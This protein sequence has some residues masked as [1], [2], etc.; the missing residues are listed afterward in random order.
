[1]PLIVEYQALLDQLAEA[2]APALTQMP[3]E[4]G[5]EMFRVAQP[6]RPD[7]EVK[8]VENRTIE[9]RNGSIPIRIYSPTGSGPFPVTMMFHGGGWVIGDLMTVDAQSR[10]VCNQVG[11]VVVAVDYRL[12]PE[13]RF[14]A[15]TEDCFDATAWVHANSSAINADPNRLAV[16]GDSAGGNLAAV[17]AQMARDEAG[18]PLVFQLLVY[19]VTNGHVFETASYREN[20]EGYML[21]AEAMHWFWDHYAD[22]NDRTHPYASPLLS[23]ELS[24]LPAAYVQVAEFDPLR[25]EGL[26]Y[27]EA[28]ANAGVSVRSTCYD[29]FIHGFFSHFDTIPPTRVAMDDACSALRE[30]F[31]S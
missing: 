16:S 20:A 10:Q 29:G 12:A 31:N 28:L 1:M 3:V 7:I 17:V 22:S 26:Q 15:A 24:N 2:A 5:R 6:E 4:A 8:S 19:P 11:C 21:T 18:P 30:A 14:P 27:A 13:H 23:K 9:G 25:D